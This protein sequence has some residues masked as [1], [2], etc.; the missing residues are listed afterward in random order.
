MTTSAAPLP[1]LAERTTARA[2]PSWLMPA[3]VGVIALAVGASIVDGLPVGVAHDDGMYVIL[4]KAIATG[5]GYRWL[6]V[7]GAPPATHFPPG[8]PAVLAVLWWLFPAF[9]ANV[10]AFK[11]ANA[12]FMA[13][14]AM[15]VYAF[16]KARFGMTEIGAAI[17][18][19][20]STLGIP[21]LTLSALVM[22]EP[23][24]LAL[25]MP[26]L[27]LAERLGDSEDGRM[28]DVVLL[29]LLVGAATLVRTHGIAL[30]GAIGLALVARRRLREAVVFG[31]ISVAMLLPWQL[32][33]SAHAGV[34]PM[35]MRGNYESYGA[36]FANGLHT[37]GFALIA[38]TVARTSRD[39]AVMFEVLVAPSMPSIVRAF[40]VLVL[41]AFS[42]VGA[43]VLWRRAPV[44]A[45]F[46][47]LYA[48]I[49]I[50]W[51]FT[52]AR[53]L[54]CV[55][56]LIIA[57]PILGAREVVAWRPGTAAMRVGRLSTIAA[58][59]LLA[60][61]YATYNVRGYRHQ[62]WSS[63]PRM[64]SRNV[65]PL[66]VWVATRTPKDA[67]LATEAESEVYLYTGRLTVPVG[68]FTVDEYF[69]ARTPAENA[70][71]ISA[72]VSHYH[73]KA[74]VVSSGA[75]RDAARELVLGTPS[76]FAVVDTFP[77]GGLVLIPRTR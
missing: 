1:V 39:V 2:I 10:I 68:T 44:S 14:A 12:L 60:C 6:H 8:Y 48:A 71:V 51:P 54:W 66:L 3:I 63:I 65:H 4:A 30:T 36:W 56:P 40:A 33:V 16:T 64:I 20:V 23:L 62:W 77:D 70:A 47:S 76:T 11:F 17:F 15:G 57:L 5:H 67:V 38:R 18:A 58:A 61:G 37:E 19:L 55:W 46:L 26:I 21:T 50:V 13:V 75:M 24:F 34:V 29:A 45:L 32:W 35:T 74:V 7:P 52:P 41:G 42:V 28:R 22:S 69:G 73:P 9:P 31:A 49:V 43:R 27:L 53:F 25:L 59:L 72:V